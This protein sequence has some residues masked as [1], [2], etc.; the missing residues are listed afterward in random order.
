MLFL[1]LHNSIG[2]VMVSVLV[3]SVVDHGFE[4]WSRLAK[5]YK[6][7]ICC[8]SSKHVALRRKS[9]DWLAQNQDNMSNYKYDFFFKW[10]HYGMKLLTMNFVHISE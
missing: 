10:I 7:G 1:T 4:H 6:I 2:G 8:F 9:K 5:D 3:L